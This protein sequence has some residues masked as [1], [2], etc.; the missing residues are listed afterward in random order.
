M[1]AILYS[2]VDSHT[3]PDDLLYN[4]TCPTWIKF[5]FDAIVSGE[6]VCLAATYC[7]HQIVSRA[8]AI[9]AAAATM[10]RFT[11][12]SEVYCDSTSTLTVAM[13]SDADSV[14]AQI[15]KWM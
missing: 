1:L 10:I 9:T 11:I 15:S 3:I 12:L 8:A 2:K 14:V 7:S 4:E 6:I 13:I 5:S